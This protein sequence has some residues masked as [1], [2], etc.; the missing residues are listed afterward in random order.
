MKKYGVIIFLVVGITIALLIY[1]KGV[2]ISKERHESNVVTLLY[3]ETNE[4]KKYEP[5]T[6]LLESGQIKPYESY[7][8]GFSYAIP[9]KIIDRPVQ[10]GL[11]I[12]EWQILDYARYENAEIIVLDNWRLDNTKYAVIYN[13]NTYFIPKLSQNSIYISWSNDN[14]HFFL[15]EKEENRMADK[16]IVHTLDLINGKYSYQIIN[17]ENENEKPFLEGQIFCNDNFVYYIEF[18]PTSEQLLLTKYIIKTNSSSHYYLEGLTNYFL[19]KDE[20]LLVGC[21]PKNEFIIQRLDY[22]FTLHETYKVTLP[23]NYVFGLFPG[24]EKMILQD[25][26]IL[27]GIMTTPE[28]ETAYFGYDLN[29]KRLTDFIKIDVPNNTWLMDYSFMYYNYKQELIQFKP[30]VSNLHIEHFVKSALALDQSDKDESKEAATDSQ[31]LEVMTNPD[32][33]EITADATASESES[34]ALYGA[35]TYSQEPAV[36]DRSF[37]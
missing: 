25:N 37:Q 34:S 5:S 36:V 6:A 23:H 7:I 32:V 15:Y 4:A 27:N 16:L 14:S 3:F 35:S 8:R 26:N 19:T 1:D 10:Y 20:I 33:G 31:V 12:E 17:M 2:D 13:S 24:K 29:D 11:N 21:S 22:N 30:H 28:G 18:L 9:E